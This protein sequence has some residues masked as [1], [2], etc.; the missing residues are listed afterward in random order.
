MTTRL[1]LVRH[2]E[3]DS[4][5]E[6]RTQGRRDVPLNERGRRQAAALAEM[7]REHAPT[8]VYSSPAGRARETAGA[9]AGAL[10]LEVTIDERLAEL[11]HSELDGLTGAEMR[12]RYPEFLRRWRDEDPAELRIPGGESMGDAQIRMVAAAE[13]IA[14]THRDGTVVIASHNLALHALICHA[15][16]TPLAS[17]RQFRQDLAA[18]TI[19]EVYDDGAFA[20]VTLNERCHLPEEHLPQE[21]DAR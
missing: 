15:L 17:F 8:T 16:G 11:D 4:N 18:L 6:G 10:G 19:L 21:R 20:V 3:T 1:L 12:E 14:K 7:L 13:S 2:G 9:V 5:A